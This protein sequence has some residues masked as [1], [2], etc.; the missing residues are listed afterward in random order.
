MGGEI[1]ICDKEPG[2]K[3]TCFK[4][5]IFLRSGEVA[6]HETIRHEE[7]NRSAI[8]E[9]FMLSE[10]HSMKVHSLLFVQGSETKR[11][12]QTWIESL[13]IKVWTAK[14]AEHI[15][16]TLEKIKHSINSSSKS[17]SVLLCKTFSRK[18]DNVEGEEFLFSPEKNSAP[19]PR[20]ELSREL[21]LRIL[22]I[23]DL[24]SGKHPEILTNLTEFTGRNANLCC[25]IACISDSKVNKNDLSQFRGLPCDLLLRKPIHGSRL[26]NLFRLIQELEKTEESYINRAPTYPSPEPPRENQPEK[27]CEITEE[28]SNVVNSKN[29]LRGKH[30]LLVD[31]DFVIRRVGSK[32]LSKLGAEVEVAENGLEALD[33]VKKALERGLTRAQHGDYSFTYD[34]IFMDCQVKVIKT[35]IQNFTAYC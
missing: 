10:S 31:D 8:S 25:K 22:V 1:S 9:P 32:V 24:S 11:I 35:F 6:L 29:L 2:E 15:S 5:N 19:L 34:A 27:H 21:P 13:G 26:H 16:P 3:G 4:F 23:V 20:A 28:T 18:N 12:L 7:A 30:V 17:D 14:H 33:L